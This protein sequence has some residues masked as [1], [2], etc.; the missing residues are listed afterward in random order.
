MF[1]KLNIH[2]IFSRL[3]G[4]MGSEDIRKVAYF[5]QSIDPSILKVCKYIAVTI[6]VHNNAS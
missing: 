2:I 3:G 4:G 6:M 5:E 1:R